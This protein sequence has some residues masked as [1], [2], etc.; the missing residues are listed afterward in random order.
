MASETQPHMADRV[1]ASMKPM[2]MTF[3]NQAADG[4]PPVPETRQLPKRHHSVLPRR[5]FGQTWWL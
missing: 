5:E 2:Q 4:A 3:G 1:D